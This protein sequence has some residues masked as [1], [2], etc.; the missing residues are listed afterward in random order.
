MLRHQDIC[1][2]LIQKYILISA[3]FMAVKTF[4]YVFSKT[5][6]DLLNY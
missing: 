6:Y 3:I 2:Y 5:I 4:I 1:D